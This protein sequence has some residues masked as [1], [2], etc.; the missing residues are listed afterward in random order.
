MDISRFRKAK[1]KTAMGSILVPNCNGPALPV[2]LYQKVFGLVFELDVEHFEDLGC[3]YLHVRTPLTLGSVCMRWRNVVLGMPE[4]WTFMYCKAPPFKS[5][6]ARNLKPGVRSRVM[7]Y[8]RI[9]Q[10][11]LESP[12]TRPSNVQSLF[13]ERCANLPLRICILRTSRCP[14]F[15]D[16]IPSLDL[17]PSHRIRQIS[18]LL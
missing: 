4:L 9:G 14:V 12:S 1:I 7:R 16:Q 11:D 3:V 8:L 17:F 5:E 2:E 15:A 6:I 18:L 13:L 10:K